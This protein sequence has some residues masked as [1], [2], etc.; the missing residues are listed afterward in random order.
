MR[1]HL[2]PLL[3]IALLLTAALAFAPQAEACYGICVE[4]SPLCA[5]CQTSST[6]TGVFCDQSGPCFCFLRDKCQF[7]QA[8]Q[9]QP[10]FLA[11]E[12][13]QTPFV[14]SV[15]PGAVTEPEDPEFLAA[16]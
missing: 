14:P 12:P 10:E 6:Y 1:R 9:S 5:Q 4:V 13:S 8:D 16:D 3:G 7:L 11:P 15:A 2:L